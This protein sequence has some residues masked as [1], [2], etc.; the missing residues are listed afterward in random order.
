MTFKTKATREKVPI[1][2]LLQGA[3]NSG[4]TFSALRLATGIAGDR[5]PIFVIDTENRRASAYAGHHKNKHGEFDFD[6]IV[7]NVSAPYTYD[8]YIKLIQEAEQSGQNPVLIIDS[9]T[10]EWAGSGGLLAKKDEID[11]RGGNT[12]ANWRFI[13]GKHQSFIDAILLSPLDII[14]TVRAKQAYSLDE[15]NVPVKMGLAPVQRDGVEYEFILSWMILEDH[16][17]KVGKDNTGL[18]D[19]ETEILTEAIGERILVWRESAPGDAPKPEP[20]VSKRDEVV[21]L[22]KELFDNEAEFNTWV[23][24]LPDTKIGT[25]LENLKALEATK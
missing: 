15:K 19:D 20:E 17:A 10:H 21:R 7:E 18:F 1:K 16:T 9:I 3:S 25:I 14:C 11:S 6:F 4:K 23:E 22:R 13:S 2:I 5:R 24:T 8:K 12:Y